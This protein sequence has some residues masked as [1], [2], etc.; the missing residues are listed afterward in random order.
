VHGTLCITTAGGTV[1]KVPIDAGAAVEIAQ[2]DDVGQTA[3][4]IDI[5]GAQHAGAPRLVA[6]DGKAVIYVD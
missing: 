5:G 6:I 4:V 1:I 3:F 2:G